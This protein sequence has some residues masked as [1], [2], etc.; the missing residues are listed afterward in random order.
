MA[1]SAG[2]GVVRFG[3]P[4]TVSLCMLVQ[5]NQR[6]FKKVRRLGGAGPGCMLGEPWRVR[7]GGCVPKAAAAMRPNL[8][9]GWVACR[10]HGTSHS[11]NGY[12]PCAPAA[13]DWAHRRAAVADGPALERRS[14]GGAR[15]APD[16]VDR[17]LPRGRA[18]ARGAAAGPLQAGCRRRPRAPRES[19][20]PNGTWQKRDALRPVGSSRSTRTLGICP[21]GRR[22]GTERPRLPRPVRVL[23]DGQH[24]PP[25]F[26]LP[27]SCAR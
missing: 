12:N 24:H 19:P 9:R 1:A 5:R 27:R 26:R 23:V 22:M 20:G 21:T 17:Q 25:L 15:R 18:G 3:G 14:R 16:K 10:P 8:H 11:C 7:P 6:R 13:T 2:N 4:N